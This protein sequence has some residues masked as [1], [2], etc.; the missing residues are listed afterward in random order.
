MIVRIIMSHHSILGNFDWAND[1][2]DTVEWLRAEA[3]RHKDDVPLKNMTPMARLRHFDIAPMAT[4]IA[5]RLEVFKANPHDWRQI[6]T[7][8]NGPHVWQCTKCFEWTR[9]FNKPNPN[10][11]LVDPDDGYRYAPN[12]SYCGEKHG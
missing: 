8:L 9:S 1:F 6:S 11:D 5:D 7:C 2:K 12:G 4:A 10:C 3:E